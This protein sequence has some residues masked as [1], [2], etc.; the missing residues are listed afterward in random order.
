MANHKGMTLSYEDLN[1]I[2]LVVDGRI[3]FPIT[4][5]EEKDGPLWKIEK[6]WTSLKMIP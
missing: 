3:K 6:N 5:F 4:E 2:E 1:P